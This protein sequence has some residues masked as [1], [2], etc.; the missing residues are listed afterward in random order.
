MWVYEKD[1]L[2]VRP[3][4]PEDEGCQKFYHAFV[5]DEGNRDT[6][7]IEE[8]FEKIETKTGILLAKIHQREKLYDQDRKD[9]SLFISF[10]F[11]R[12]PFFRNEIEKMA[13]EH[14]KHVGLDVAINNF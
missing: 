13:A 5:T 1:S 10:M 11:T 3:S 6:N 8:Y 4:S 14:I 7:T 9:L 2:A 12:V